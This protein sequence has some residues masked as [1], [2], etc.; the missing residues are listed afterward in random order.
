MFEAQR[1]AAHYGR[2][3]S[4]HTRFHLSTKPPTESQIGADE[5]IANAVALKAPLIIAHDNDYGWWENEEKLRLLREQGF[6]I[7]AEYYPYD[8]AG[9]QPKADFFRPEIWEGEY[10]YKY[11]E[12][13]FD[14]QANKFLNK[15]EFL[16][17]RKSDPTRAIVTYF[18][19]RK[20]WLPYWLRMPDMTVA[21][22]A[23]A[24]RGENGRLLPA[25]AHV[26]EYRGHPRTAGASVRAL[27]LGREQ[28]V[29]LM[30][31]LSQLSYWSAKHLGDTGLEAMK[32]RGRVQVGK[33]ADLTLFDPK[34]VADNANF[35][36][37]ENGLPPTG[38]PYVIINGT[39]VVKDGKVLPV[40]PGQPIRF[41]VEAKG[42]FDPV[43]VNKWFGD[44]V[45]NVPDMHG[46]DDS[47]AGHIT[48]DK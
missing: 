27:R 46:M 14:P 29:P 13:I 40:K 17:L 45:I 44:H 41:P 6:N 36:L 25:N 12:T 4:V 5:V 26:S 34:T 1:A 33:A 43:T 19:A 48:T 39:V 31:T 38:V 20:K 3:T 11:E 10:G 22:D 16:S 32:Q 2:L 23:I 15:E 47:G 37:G 7:W 9:G 18:P 30:F 24:G 42:R 21:S 35:R 28:G 8:A